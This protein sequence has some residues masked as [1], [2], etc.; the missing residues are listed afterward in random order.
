MIAMNIHL[1]SIQNTMHSQHNLDKYARVPMK[2]FAVNRKPVT[3][4]LFSVNTEVA[5]LFL[6]IDK[7]RFE[8]DVESIFHV[9]N[10]TMRM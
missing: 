2:Y 8:R 7:N 5:A 3:N 4:I 10:Y 9:E 6:I 1:F